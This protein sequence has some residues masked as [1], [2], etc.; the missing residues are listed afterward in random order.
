LRLTILTGNV[1]DLAA[2]FEIIT[3]RRPIS[4]GLPLVDG[5]TVIRIVPPKLRRLVG[6]VDESE[7]VLYP[8]ENSSALVAR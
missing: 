8:F 5:K 2:D 6:C 4:Y 1:G 3:H 7:S